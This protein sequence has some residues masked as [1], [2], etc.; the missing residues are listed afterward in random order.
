MDFKNRKYSNGFVSDFKEFRLGVRDF[1]DLKS[2]CMDFWPGFRGFRS[3][4]KCYS[5][6]IPGISSRISIISGISHRISRFS[7]I[8]G[9]ILRITGVSG[10]ISGILGQIS[11]HLY[12]GFHSSRPLVQVYLH[13][14]AISQTM[15]PT[16]TWNMAPE[17]VSQSNAVGY[18]N[19]STP[20]AWYFSFGRGYS[21]VGAN[22]RRLER[23]QC[24]FN[25]KWLRRTE[26]NL[27]HSI[28]GR[29]GNSHFVVFF[30][31]YKLRKRLE[32]SWRTPIIACGYSSPEFPWGSFPIRFPEAR[33]IAG[34]M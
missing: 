31:T 11:G 16:K 21:P 22:T 13:K 20:N 18:V 29:R 8:F 17:N 32:S 3:D 23:T 26:P 33:S 14:T 30:C 6:R 10:W 4:W 24:I 2:V 12:T 19:M 9:Q 28:W 15:K 1:R 27:T 25:G 7:E 5:G 34:R